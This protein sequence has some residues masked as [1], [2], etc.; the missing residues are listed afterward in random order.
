M[1]TGP[2]IHTTAGRA[3]D[4]NY[5]TVLAVSRPGLFG[6][7]MGRI[8]EW[9]RLT[10]RGFLPPGF[11]RTMGPVDARLPEMQLGLGVWTDRVQRFYPIEDIA[12]HPD[13][14]LADF[15]DPHDIIVGIDLR[16]RIP[17]AEYANHRTDSTGPRR[18]PMQLMTRWYGF[19][20]TFPDC[21]IYRR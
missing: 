14:A 19:C 12:S 16:T 17:Y 21:E 6:R 2:L 4:D 3:V 20:L 7:C 1:Q 5:K 11:R 9:T 10:R 8:A 18:R 13:G 15:V